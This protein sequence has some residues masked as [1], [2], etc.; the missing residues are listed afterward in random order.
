MFGSTHFCTYQLC[1]VVMRIYDKNLWEYL[2]ERSTPTYDLLPIAERF[3]IFSNIFS[4]V[5]HI[6]S[7]GQLHLDLKPSNILLNVDD[8]GKWNQRDLVVT[9]FGIGG[10]TTMLTDGKRHK[11]R[12]T[13]GFASPE[14]L[15]G[16]PHRKGG[17]YNRQYTIYTS[18]IS[19]GYDKGLQ[20]RTRNTAHL[21]FFHKKLLAS[22]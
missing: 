19:N 3:N 12:G 9:D 20:A 2:K 13:P 21:L 1:V 7:S 10:S 4:A 6:Q 8:T 17:G 22:P 16:I 5:M 18:Y 15:L 11:I 14:Q